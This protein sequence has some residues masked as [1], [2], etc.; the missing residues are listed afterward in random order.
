MPSKGF[1]FSVK[2]VTA[3]RVPYYHKNL[4]FIVSWSQKAGCTSVFK[5]FL[6]HCG[7]YDEAIDYLSDSHGL[8]IHSYELEVLR[9]S[10]GYRESIE[11]HLHNGKPVVNFL[12]CP[13]QRAFSSYM[14][15]NNRFFIRQVMDGASSPGLKVREDLLEFVY[16]KG[17]S[18]EYP[19]SFMDYL[20]WLDAGEFEITDPHHKPQHSEIFKYEN[21]Q[22]YRLEDFEACAGEL[23]RQYGLSESVNQAVNFSTGH[24]LKKD[25][26][27]ENCAL[28]LLEKS[29]PMNRSENFRIPLVTQE[30]LAGTKFE[31]H[32]RRIFAN[33]VALYESL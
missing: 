33:D 11:R 15:L 8:N 14:H 1:E 9:K 26:V 3:Y 32:I 29:F 13:Y 22:H 21:T 30:M 31:T 5:W 23:E 24:H 27:P 18:V 6:F 4:P 28:K 10:S 7:L 16:G 17:A 2:R 20:K 25:V 19:V 12:R